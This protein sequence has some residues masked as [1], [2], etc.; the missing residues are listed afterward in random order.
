MASKLLGRRVLS[1][2]V[3][4]GVVAGM[5]AFSAGPAT[6][7]VTCPTVSQS[8]GAVSP[9]PSPGADWSGCNLTG[10]DLFDLHLNGMNLTGA[11]LTNAN[12]LFD[13][14]SS[15]LTDANF[16]GANMTGDNLTAATVTGANMATANLDNVWTFNTVGVPAS[17]PSGWEDVSDH[18]LGPTANLTFATLK[19]KD[20]AGYDLDEANLSQAN[21]TD[22]NLAGT[23]LGQATLDGVQSGGITGTPS[24]PS[25]WQLTD[26]YLIGSGANLGGATL[27][28]ADLTDA[29]LS[30]TDFEGA[31]LSGA[32]LGGTNLTT[33]NLD[34]A[35]LS[36]ASLT[37]ADAESATLVGADLTSTTLT[38]AAL[39]DA[40]LS[41]ATL[42]GAD[43]PT[44]TLTGIQ[45]GGIAVDGSSPSLPANWSLFNG[46]LVGPAANL[47]SAS[48]GGLTL[49]NADLSSA[50][51]T[52]AD[53]TNAS[54]PSADLVSTNL[55]SA[56]LTGTTLTSADLTS[57]NL[58]DAN[59]TDANLDG[60]ATDNTVTTGVTWLNTTCPD[61][62]N[63]NDHDSGCFSP[64]NTTPP[65]AHPRLLSAGTEVNG[66][67]NAPVTVEWS[68]TDA[69]P[70]NYADCTLSSTTTASGPI[71]LTA[72]CT[73]LAGHTATDSYKL[74]VDT[75]SPVV[76][77]TGVAAKDQYVLGKVPQAGCSTT[78]AISGV[79]KAAKV[80]VSTGGTHGVGPFTAT[81][82][83]AVSV[84]GNPQPAPVQAKYTVGYGFGGFSAPRPGSTIAKSSHSITATFRLVNAAGTAV[85]AATASNLAFAHDVRVTLR[86]PG[87]STVSA[88][89][90]WSTTAHV[91]TC[92]LKIPAKVLTARKYSLSAEENV[93]TGFYAVPVAGKVVNP[94]TIYF[95]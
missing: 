15:N 48:L 1:V 34:G 12:L 94:E 42:T 59:L 76:Q 40:N 93:G 66:W 36:Q 73:D 45:S 50:N 17:L 7:A 90:Q 74:K 56:N 14:D 58:T 54:L 27:T 89:C 23:D 87:I 91:L 39:T 8:T 22:T 49:T 35:N 5:L 77:V 84:A 70:L 18:I 30:D 64:F 2:I 21:L 41:Q 55:T 46:Y 9:P 83:G 11:N 16:S 79:E 44:A 95:K 24:I 86:G 26:G 60:A 31:D 51:L 65:V 82:A 47:A 19:G 88:F 72:S 57:T 29:N 63:S 85:S 25:G 13:T 6:A 80:S 4:G 75:T 53:L 69:G 33:A 71:T 81:C 68:W 10:A 92:A 20:L 3:A 38:Q 52:S 78:E 28:D 43:L 61:G 62:S 37:N 32:D 67:F